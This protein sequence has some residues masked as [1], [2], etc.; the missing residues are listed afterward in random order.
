MARLLVGTSGYSYK[1]WKGSFYPQ[2]LSPKDF[3][4]YYAERL[5]TV[6]INNTFYR[7]P[8]RDVLLGWRDEVPAGFCFVLKTP[9]R[10]THHKRLGDVAEDLAYF[11][12]T[13]RAL[14][15]HLGPLLV[16]LPPYLRRDDQKLAAFLALV[17]K[18]VRVAVEFR[19]ASWRDEAVYQLLRDHGAAACAADTDDEEEAAPLVS[20]ADWGYLRLRRLAYDEAALTAWLGRI[21]AQP[22]REAFVF[23]KH[24]DAGTGPRLARRLIALAR[25]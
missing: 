7:M 3:L 11:C 5:G 12:E 24:E 17:P 22:W 4:R 14:G 19:H 18:D 10:I 1:E 13:A 2:D 23:F 25:G 20:T 8:K 9:Q 21:A 6:E 16:Q 15:P